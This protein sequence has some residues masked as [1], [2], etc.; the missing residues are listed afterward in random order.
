MGNC[1]P[2]NQIIQMELKDYQKHKITKTGSRRN[3]KCER[4]IK[5]KEI[6]SII[7]TS[8]QNTGPDGFTGRFYQTFK[9]EITPILQ[10]FSQKIEEERTLPNTFC[11]VNIT[12][13]PKLCKDIIR[14]ENYGL[15]SLMNINGKILKRIPANQIQQ[16]IKAF[17]TMA[18]L[19]LSQ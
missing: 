3:R 12:L 2:T 19:N 10:I 8:Q 11:E 18:K 13:I 4:S 5:S 17:Y 14:K 7:K 15:I 6:E 1:T 16:H 9:K